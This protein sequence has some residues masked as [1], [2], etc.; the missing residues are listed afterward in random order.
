MTPFV[1]VPSVQRRMFLCAAGNSLWRVSRRGFSSAPGFSRLANPN[2]QTFKFQLRRH[3][4]ILRTP[5]MICVVLLAG[6]GMVSA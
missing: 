6:L 1:C 3:M 4:K 2:Q 5:S